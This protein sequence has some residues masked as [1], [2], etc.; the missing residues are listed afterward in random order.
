ML[1]IAA[2]V[3]F[4]TFPLIDRKTDLTVLFALGYNEW[5]K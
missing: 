3:P 5:R 1:A 4:H 2:G